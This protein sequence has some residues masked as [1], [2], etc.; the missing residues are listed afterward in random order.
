MIKSMTGFGRSEYS[1]GKRNIT[2]EI[3]SVNHR[4]SDITVKMPRRYSFAEDK[5]KQAVKSKLARGKVDVSINVENVTENDVV[6]KLNQLAAKQY[7][8]NLKELKENFDLSGDIDLELLATMPDV[9]KAVPDVDDEEE[10]TKA[11]LIPVAEASANLES[12]RAIEGQRL[13]D[14]LIT[15]GETIKAILDQIEERSPLVVKDYME[16]LRARIAELLDGAAEIPEDR[17]LTEA[18][19][20]ADKCAIDEEITRLN[21]H[22][23]QLKSILTGSESTVGKKLDFLVQE[24]NREANTIGSKAN[25]ITI[26]NHMLNIKAEIEKIREQVQNIE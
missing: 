24:M 13:A 21:S 15:K 17:I 23:L 25:D 26:T 11:I 4:Y 6:I 7:Y 12:M 9:L 16:K 8:D 5:I 18:A 1:D 22:L 3:K 19:I 2:C 10:L 20:F 14:D